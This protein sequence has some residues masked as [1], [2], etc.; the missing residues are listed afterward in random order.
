[1]CENFKPDLILLGH[2][3]KIRLKT[4]EKIKS[5]LPNVKISQW[6]LDPITKKGPDYIKNKKRLLDKFSVIDATFA[7]THPNEIDFIN[8]KDKYPSSSALFG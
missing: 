6:F 8:N 3:D 1:M 4:L 7:T 2:A 5:E